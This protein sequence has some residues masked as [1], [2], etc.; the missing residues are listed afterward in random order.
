MVGLSIVFLLNLKHPNPKEQLQSYLIVGLVATMIISAYTK[1]KKPKWVL[2]ILRHFEKPKDLINFPAKGAIYYLIGVL[3]A[4]VLFDKDIASASILILAVGDPAGHIV[5]RYYGTKRLV[6]NRKKLLE[7]TLAGIFFS[8]IAASFFVSV[9][10]AFFG[11]SF[12]MMAEAIEL[13]FLELDDNFSIPFIS[14]LV[15]NLIKSLI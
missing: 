15:M 13:K 10:V 1:Q 7:G 11:A 14:G 3:I 5:G 9:P 12:G 4:I 8:T 2:S 6:I